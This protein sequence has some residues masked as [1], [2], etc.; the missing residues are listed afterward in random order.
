M[1]IDLSE[2]KNRLSQLIEAVQAG[3]EVVIANLDAPMVRL[4]A[5]GAKAV[6]PIVGDAHHIL[7]W[8][9]VHPLPAYAQ[10]SAEE[11]DTAIEEERR[12]WG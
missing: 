2:A 9:R 11:I 8:L 4:V 12:S 10:R 6:R 5:A 7:D 3:E 1:Q